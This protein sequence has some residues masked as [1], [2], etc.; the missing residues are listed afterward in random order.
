VSQRQVRR[1]YVVGAKRVVIK[2]GSG[3]LTGPSGLNPRRVNDY[4]RQISALLNDRKEVVL[5]SSGAIASGFKKI[6][7]SERPRTVRQQQACAAVG[8][9]GL[10]MTY[11]RA[12]ARRGYKVAQ[13]LLTADDLSNRRRYLNAHN[14]M[15]ALLEWKVL[16]IVNEN[17]TVVVAEIKYGDNDTLGAL[18]T[19]LVEA[20][21]FINLTDMD[22]LY[23]CDPRHN[24]EACFIPVVENVGSRV[25]A[26]ASGIPSSLG[27]GGMRTKLVAARKLSQQGV[28][29]II[30]NGTTP[31]I[32][33]KILKGEELGT[34]FLPR[35]K[36][37]R[38][39]KHWIAHASRK[40]GG[41]VVDAGAKKALLRK[42]C[43][44]LPRGVVGV[45]G[46]FGPGD[47]VQ[48]IDRDGST[49]AVGVTNYSSEDLHKIAGV[50]TADIESVLGYKHSDEVIDGHNMVV[51]EDLAG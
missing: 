35:E 17:D 46:R 37:L 9:A 15:T 48:V 47:S 16:P 33:L 3:V 24:A 14:T 43:S 30:A 34:L 6:G 1:K 8:Q 32:L 44:L 31:N 18:V 25:E 19:G 39:R 4:A 21:L 50:H 12:F 41:I 38:P 51:G 22:G 40:N 29:S 13:V 7:L 11:E 36:A 42:N 20:D 5:V 2:I 23:D 45:L 49:V 10:M 28:P 26:M 27:S